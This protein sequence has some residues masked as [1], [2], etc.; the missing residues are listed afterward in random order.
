MRKFFVG[1]AAAAAFAW[2]PAQSQSVGELRAQYAQTQDMLNQAEVAGMDQS[3]VASLRESL[4]GLRQVIEDMEREQAESSSPQSEAVSEPAP[5]PVVAS[6][7]PNLAAGT[8]GDFGVTEDNYRQASLEPGNDVQVR[9]M[10]GQALEYYA[11]YKRAV[12][13][14]HP[15]AWRTY[16]AHRQ[17]S[18]QLTSF[19]RD[20]RAAP[21][22]GI[23]PDTKSA[24]QVEAERREAAARA[25]ADAPPPPPK[26]P[27]CDGCV[28]PQ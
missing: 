19:D 25:M 23:V 3:L 17:A 7:E 15:E 20:T 5:A 27:P 14:G 22:E 11:M 9:S 6:L 16:D 10:C 18:A 8:C 21:A 12:A 26:A 1:A 4:D 2:S 28:T 13:Q 24:T